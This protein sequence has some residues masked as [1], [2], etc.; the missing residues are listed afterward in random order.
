LNINQLTFQLSFGAVA[1]RASARIGFGSGQFAVLNLSN[2]GFHAGREVRKCPAVGE[3]FFL[4]FP[5]YGAY[6]DLEK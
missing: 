2:C 4:T 1:L 3:V 6:L 5:C